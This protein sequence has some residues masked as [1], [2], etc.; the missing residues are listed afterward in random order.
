MNNSM[1]GQSSLVRIYREGCHM[2]ASILITARRKNLPENIQWTSV[3][4]ARPS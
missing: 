4:P 3:K 1:M 2:A